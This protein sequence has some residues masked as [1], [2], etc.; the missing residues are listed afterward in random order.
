MNRHLSSS[1]FAR[2][3][4]FFV[5]FCKA[6]LQFHTFSLDPLASDGILDK[7]E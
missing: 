2:L 1:V 6:K 4:F 7:S 5:F 3:V